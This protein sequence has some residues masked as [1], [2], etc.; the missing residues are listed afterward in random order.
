MDLAVIVL[1]IGLVIILNLVQEG[2]LPEDIWD[3]W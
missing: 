2:K 1:L 3:K